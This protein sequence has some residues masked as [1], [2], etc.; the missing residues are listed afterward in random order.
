MANSVTLL[1]AGSEVHG[2]DQANTGALSDYV[3]S[4]EVEEMNS[5][6]GSASD[7]PGSACRDC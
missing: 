1:S 5:G 3:G 2:G 4:A 6:T 7:F